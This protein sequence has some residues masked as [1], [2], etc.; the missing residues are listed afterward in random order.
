M[1][2]KPAWERQFLAVDGLIPAH[3]GK[4]SST[5]PALAG[6]GAHPRACGE[7]IDVSVIV[8]VKTGSSPRMRGKRAGCGLDRFSERLIPAHAGKTTITADS[9]S[10]TGAHP[11]AC[12]ENNLN[13][14]RII[15]AKGSSP[16]MRG[17]P[18]MYTIGRA[19][20]RLIPAH[21]GK[22]TYSVSPASSTSAHPR[23]CGENCP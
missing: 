17:K 20:E 23:A 14:R 15:G 8:P 6:N 11:R 4:T 13:G 16:R 22:T 7:N 18:D 10:A 21:A 12:G 1:R 5:L 3:A 2:G 19:V 9:A